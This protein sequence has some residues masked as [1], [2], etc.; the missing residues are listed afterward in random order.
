MIITILLVLALVFCIVGL[1]GAP[2]AP[3]FGLSL[4]LT[5]IALLL[6]RAGVS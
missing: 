3:W 6:P 5:I 1:V 2:G 4:L